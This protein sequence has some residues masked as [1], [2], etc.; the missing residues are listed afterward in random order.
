MAKNNS[1][2]DRAPVETGFNCP[3][4]GNVVTKGYKLV[5]GTNNMWRLVKVKSVTNNNIGQK[6]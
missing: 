5:R 3:T 1:N 2:T 6:R 4:I